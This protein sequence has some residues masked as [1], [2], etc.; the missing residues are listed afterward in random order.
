[1]KNNLKLNS[2]QGGVIFWKKFF[3][4]L[5]KPVLFKLECFRVTSCEV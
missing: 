1:M 5:S 4:K 3:K 2:L